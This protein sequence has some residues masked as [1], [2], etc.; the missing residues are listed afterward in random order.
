MIFVKMTVFTCNSLKMSF[1]EDFCVAKSL[2]NCA[3][4]I[5]GNYFRFNCLLGAHPVKC[6]SNVHCFVFFSAPRSCLLSFP[7]AGVDELVAL[8]EVQ[9]FECDGK[10]QAIEI[11][12]FFAIF[13]VARL[14]S[15]FWSQVFF[16]LRLSLRKRLRN[17]PR[18]F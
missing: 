5:L 4:K 18:S 13:K 14:Q 15:E 1:P 11:V 3:H 6:C 9:A 12:L 10:S 7:L 8:E 17:V 16:E 2:Q